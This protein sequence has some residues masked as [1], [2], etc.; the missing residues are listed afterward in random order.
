MRLSSRLSVAVIAP[1]TL[2]VR[3]AVV[4]GPTFPFLIRVTL[5][6]QVKALSF[7]QDTPFRLL[8]FEQMGSANV[9]KNAYRTN[10]QLMGGALSYRKDSSAHELELLYALLV[11]TQN[12][13]QKAFSAVCLVESIFLGFLAW[14]HIESS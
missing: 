13:E 5:I 12:H 1:F 8:E 11:T 7:F 6:L 2:I 4:A 14:F 10:Q 9:Q 3:V